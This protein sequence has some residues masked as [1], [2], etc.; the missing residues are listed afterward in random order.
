MKNII[1]TDSEQEVLMFGEYVGVCWNI[2]KDEICPTCGTIGEWV[3]ASDP[4]IDFLTLR[5]SETG[6]YSEDD[7]SVAGGIGVKKAKK[8]ASELA[9][10]IKYI[11]ELTNTKNEIKK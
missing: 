5:N 8:V 10:A 7:C 4:Y 9:A 1:L 11:D 6:V 2:S 3:R